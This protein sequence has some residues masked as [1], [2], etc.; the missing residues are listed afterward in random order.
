MFRVIVNTKAIGS[1]SFRQKGDTV[2]VAGFINMEFLFSG[3]GYI[4]ENVR[5]CVSEGEGLL[6]DN[7][8]PVYCFAC[9]DI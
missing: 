5:M 3:M 8:K 4:T 6:H 9:S 1:E 2:R 7:R